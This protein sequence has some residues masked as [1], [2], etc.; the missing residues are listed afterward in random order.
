MMSISDTYT[1]FNGIVKQLC[2][3]DINVMSIFDVCMIINNYK[4]RQKMIW[5]WYQ[6]NADIWYKY[7][8]QNQ[9]SKTIYQRYQCDV[10]IWCSIDIPFESQ[11]VV[12]M[13]YRYDANIWWIYDV[14]FLW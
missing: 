10:H 3:Q 1:T 8:L 11:N 6:Y 14:Q 13:K 4:K 5:I 9:S 12:Y 2:T 7:D